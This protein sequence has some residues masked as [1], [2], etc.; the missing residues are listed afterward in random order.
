VTDFRENATDFQESGIEQSATNTRM[1]GGG[2]L[3]IGVAILLGIVIFL[4]SRSAESGGSFEHVNMGNFKEKVLQDKGPVLV[5]FYADWCGPCRRLA[6]VLEE[7]AK[8]SPHVKIVKVNVDE[9]RDLAVRYQIA[10][11]PCLMVFRNGQLV[12]R[13]SGLANKTELQE[14]LANPN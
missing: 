9:N 2:L 7:F 10:S 3:L 12:G 1:L 13:R 11:I 14:F 4:T 6:P 8:E 5:D